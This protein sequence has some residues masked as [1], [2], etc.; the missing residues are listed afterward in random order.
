MK[1]FYRYL[2]KLLVAPTVIVLLIGLILPEETQAAL[3]SFTTATGTTSVSLAIPAGTQLNDIIILIFSTDING[4]TPTYP[5]GF[6]QLDTTG[7]AT[8]DGQQAGIA[9][10]R[11]GANESGTYDITNLTN[12]TDTQGV[13]MSFS[14]RDTK[15]SPTL[16]VASSAASNAS[17]VTIN[18]SAITTLVND[19]LAWISAPDVT[20]TGAGNR[21][22]FP[23][24]YASQLDVENG[25][26]N[27]G[28]ATN[29]AIKSGGTGTVTGTFTMTSG[30][31]GWVAYLLRIP[32]VTSIRSTH[33]IR[34]NI[35]I[36][37][38]V[39]FR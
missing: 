30:S 16:S 19:D 12:G 9:W 4:I 29:V 28:V 10:K 33:K 22:T 38:R 13:A 26:T 2:N 8:P 37:G 32:Y 36:R 14:G 6:T 35:I 7:I 18:A 23:T 34:G 20:V 15:T 21:H 24:G 5:A 39:R 25:F 31:A 1:Y 3:R 27:I 11:A 17:P